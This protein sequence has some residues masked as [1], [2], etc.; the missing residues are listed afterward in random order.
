MPVY[1]RK[2]TV[3]ASSTK[4]E[5]IEIRGD[6][7]TKVRIRFPPGPSGL[8]KVAINYGI[9][10]VFPFEEDTWFYGD[11]EIIEWEEYWEFPE[12]PLKLKIVAENEDD[13]YDHSFYLVLVTKYKHEMLFSL[14]AKAIITAFK[15]LFGWV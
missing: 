9:K 13:T 4:E 6:I 10:R 1:S 3:N 11:D 12:K 15:R 8:L 5:E 14:I 2:V 7:I